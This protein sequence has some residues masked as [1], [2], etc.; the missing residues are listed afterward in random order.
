MNIIAN[1]SPFIILALIIIL[2]S[3][4]RLFPAHKPNNHKMWVNYSL[5]ASSILL[6]SLLPKVIEIKP[7]T[8]PYLDQFTKFNMA[9]APLWVSLIVFDFLIYWQHR[10]FHIA[11]FLW[12]FH[13]VH[14]CDHFMDHSSAY[15]FHPL[16]ILMSAIYKAIF[17]IILRPDI[18]HFITYEFVLVSMALF[19]HSNIRIPTKYNNAL[20]S[21][22]V[23]PQMHFSHHHD[24]APHMNRNYGNFL[25]IWDRIYGTYE[26]KD[27]VTFGLEGY[28]FDKADN[29]LEQLKE[30]FS[31][32]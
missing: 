29:L 2:Y 5:I 14:H 20:K 30:P 16:E 23:T 21:I 25:S 28:S 19:N 3:F 8:D 26:S 6:M 24:V 4:E 32:K 7:L 11:P 10:F 9:V 31:N 1:Y 12:R 18:S 13:R 15:R 27:D 17:V 22:F